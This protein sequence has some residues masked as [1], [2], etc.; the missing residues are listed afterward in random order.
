[1][2]D[3]VLT[4][5]QG[6][7]FRSIAESAGFSAPTAYRAYLKASKDIPVCIDVT[8]NYCSRFCGILLVDGKYL[9]VKG[10]KKKIPVIYGID[11][12]THDIVHF[13]FGPSE[14]YNLL[15]KFFSSLK[16]ANY[17]LQAVVSDDNRNIP[18]ACLKVYPTA[19]WQLCQN[20]YKHNL[21]IT[22]NL[23]NDPTYK[24]FMRQ[25]E[26]LLSGKLSAEDFKGRA[27]KIYDKYKS[28]TLLEKIMFDIAKRSGDLTA[29]TKLHHTPRTT[30]LIESF[31]SHLQ[32][33]LKTI[34]GFKNFKHAKYWLNV[35]FFRRRLKKFTDCEKQFKK[36][37]G[38][39]SL[40]LTLSNIENY[41]T[42]LRLIK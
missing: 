22:L 4:H 2:K 11:Y 12:L 37:N 5:I 32:G 39:S 14:N 30:N 42:L 26:T 23:A 31:N 25:V 17:P 40:E 34:K 33:R 13:V 7:S 3:I 27:R 24:P 19:I 1:L 18:E 6:K 28:D 38:T 21:R 41:K 29:Y 15:L 20:H 16:L 35:Y 9:K 8:R 36:L 10:Y